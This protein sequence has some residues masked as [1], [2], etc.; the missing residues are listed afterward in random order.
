MKILK[1]ML[2]MVILLTTVAPRAQVINSDEQGKNTSYNAL[3]YSIAVPERKDTQVATDGIFSTGEWDDALHYSVAENY[4][5]FLK[6]DTEILYIGL[7]S[8]RPIG[9]LICEIRI[10][11]NEEDVFLLHVSGAL[12]EGI[13]GF[14]ATTK[15]DLNNNE[16]WEA[17]FLKADSLKNEAWIAAGR[18][19]DKYDDIYDK[20][21]GVEFKIARKKFTGNTLKLT[22]GW[23]RVEVSGKKI[24]KK[25]YN[26]PETASLKS[27]DNWVELVLPETKE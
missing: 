25:V 22:I 14:P 20:R 16:Y 11:S 19:I 10:T 6:A 17:N 15:F 3:S 24:E 27:P 26:Y 18:P 21:D 12:G 9:E 4:S 2:V 13:S 23:A 7:K 8:A 1:L 5:I